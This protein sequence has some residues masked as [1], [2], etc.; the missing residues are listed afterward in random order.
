MFC[1]T[2]PG[3]IFAHNPSIHRDWR[4]ISPV[5]VLPFL[6]LHIWALRRSV[7]NFS[8]VRVVCSGLAF[9]LLFFAYFYFWTAAG[10]ALLLGVFVDRA[11]WRIYFHTGW[12]GGLAGVPELARM[13]CSRA[14]ARDRN[15]CSGLTNSSLFRG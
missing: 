5:V 4:I 10:L 8:P 12:I 6:I 1:S 9:G 7:E 14:R 11:R 15:G 13:F 2:A 3:E